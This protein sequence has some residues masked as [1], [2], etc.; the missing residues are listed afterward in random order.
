MPTMSRPL[1]LLALIA[2]LAACTGGGAPS[3]PASSAGPPGSPG[4]SEEPAATTV[5]TGAIDHA[6]GATD[7]ILRY[8]EGGGFMMPQFVAT[9]APHFTLYGDGTIVFRNP[10]LEQPPAVGPVMVQHPYRTATLS[11]DQIQEVLDFALTEGG[12]ATAKLQYENNMVADAGTAIFT[13]HAGGV[14]K[15]VN[16]YALGLEVDGVPDLPARASFKK[17]ADRLANFDQNGTVPTDGYTPHGYRAV[18][19]DTGGFAGDAPTAWPWTDLSPAD[20]AVNEASGQFFPSRVMT[21]DEL[22]VLGVT[23][24]EGGFQGITLL[25]PEGDDKSYSLAIRPLLPDETS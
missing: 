22:A 21:A 9:Q 11:E 16:V 1:L 25:G 23:P 17:L 8:E 14:D 19:I 18:L 2:V 12:L 10:L 5:T 7:V 13:I 20:F 6:T 3:A 15:V 4:A 24:I